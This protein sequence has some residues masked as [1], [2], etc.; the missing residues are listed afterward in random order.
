MMSTRTGVPSSWAHRL[1]SVRTYSVVDA[2]HVGE[3]GLGVADGD[4]AGAA[5]GDAP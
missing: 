3:E 2:V 1:S 4:G 5:D